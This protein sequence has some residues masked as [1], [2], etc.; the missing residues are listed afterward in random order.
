MSSNLLRV[1]E[2]SPVDEIVLITAVLRES[3]SNIEVGDPIVEIE[4]SKTSYQIDA[5]VS[6]ILFHQLQ[7]GDEVH[8]G[9]TLGEIATEE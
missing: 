7:I 9:D 2:E 3:G 5:E 1:P 4:T 6:G 8:S